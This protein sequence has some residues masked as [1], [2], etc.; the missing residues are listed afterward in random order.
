MLV[1]QLVFGA[2]VVPQLFACEKSPDAE[3]ESIDR[4]SVPV[5]VSVTVCGELVVFTTW[6][7]NESAEVESRMV[8]SRAVTV[9]LVEEPPPP[10]D[11]SPRQTIT[12]KICRL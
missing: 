6:L 5:F 8:V 7:E 4:A 12:I 2:R 3:I 10:Q 9:V 1:V 11:V